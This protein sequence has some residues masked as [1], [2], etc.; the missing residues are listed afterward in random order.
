MAKWSKTLP[1]P[2][3]GLSIILSLL[4]LFCYGIALLKPTETGG[5]FGPEDEYRLDNPEKWEISIGDVPFLKNTP[6]MSKA[7]WRPLKEV[8]KGKELK[9]YKGF[10]WLRTKLPDQTLRDPHLMIVAIQSYEVFIGQDRLL[11]FH[12]PPL[13]PIVNEGGI[14]KLISLDANRLNEPLYMRIYSYSKPPQNLMGVTRYGNEGDLISGMLALHIITFSFGVIFSIA[15]VI[16]LFFYFLRERNLLYLSFSLFT[17]MA[18]IGTL[19]KSAIGHW[20]VSPEKFVH[21]P[22]IFPNLGLVGLILFLEQISIQPYKIWFRVLNVGALIYTVLTFLWIELNIDIY[23]TWVSVGGPT[24]FS[25]SLMVT[26][27]LLIKMH[28]RVKTKETHYLVYGFTI[29][30]FFIFLQLLYMFF[31]PG[32]QALLAAKALWLHLLIGNFLYIGILLFI[33]SLALVIYSRFLELN[34]K[35]KQ[36]AEETSQK[37]ED[38]LRETAATLA[39]LSVMEERNKLARDV[40]DIVGHTLTTTIVQIEATRMLLEKD[41]DKGLEKLASISQLVRKSMDDIRHSMKTLSQSSD[42]WDLRKA[43]SQLLEDTE[44][45]TGIKIEYDIEDT[46]ELKTTHKKVL[47]HALQEGVTNAIRHGDCTEIHFQLKHEEG[48][49]EFHLHNNGKPYEP[50]ELGL[51]LTAMKDRVQSV[52]GTFTIG[53]HNRTGCRIRIIMGQ[54]DRS[55]DPPY[56]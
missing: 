27:I 49:V 34:K 6:D 50:N 16:S 53:T 10:Y 11:S 40:H 32:L 19:N 55:L 42:H 24:H 43:L 9:R 20:F 46:P 15:G 30:S 37:L 3:T 21:L 48:Q 35:V 22:E 44:T 12:M 2:L 54:R 29:F 36:Y 18:G 52:G 4:V 41:R 47:F 7:K 17:L 8:M 23:Y 5:K 13:E 33:C 1:N 14:R 56:I 51:G 39:E 25:I 45:A 26:I 31:M 28:T 38:S